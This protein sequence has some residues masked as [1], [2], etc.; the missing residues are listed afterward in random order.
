VSGESIRRFV[1]DLFGSR[2]VS[3]LEVEILQIRADCELRLRD[4]D[5]VIAS[6][7]TEKAALEMKVAEYEREIMPLKTRT[8]AA[9][10]AN[11]TRPT[12]PSWQTNPTDFL[13]QLPK[14]RW[15]QYQDDWYQKQ[16]ADIKAEKAE[17][18]E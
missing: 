2:L 1:R 6:L 3:H 18:K 14:T 10:V 12:K 5:E 7:R 4:K 15:E 13:S 16:E 9:I 17:A 8:G 11:A